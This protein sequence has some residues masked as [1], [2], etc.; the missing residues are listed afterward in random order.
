[1]IQEVKYTYEEVEKIEKRLAEIFNTQRI[2]FWK[3]S[4]YKDRNF[5]YFANVKTIT[6]EIQSKWSQTFHNGSYYGIAKGV[7]QDSLHLTF[8]ITI[9]DLKEVSKN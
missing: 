6:P 7:N 5:V 1:M 9:E 3:R 4:D 8:D 2:E